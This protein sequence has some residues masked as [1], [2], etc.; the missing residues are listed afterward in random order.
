METTEARIVRTARRIFVEN[1]YERTS[2]GDI[3]AVA[4]VTRTTLH[5]YFRTKD[6]LF[7]AVFGSVVES[8]LPKVQHILGR[9][10]PFEERLE[11][12]IGEY[13]KIFSENPCLP[14]FVLGESR[15]DMD[16][17][18]A[19]VRE[20][21]G[22]DYISSIKRSLLREMERGHI[23][24]VPF[25]VLFLNFYS[26]LTYPF[27]ARDLMGKLFCHDAAEFEAFVAEWKDNVLSQM[28]HLLG[29]R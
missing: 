2:M 1:G 25:P 5:Y 6:R 9:E 22:A 14:A 21:K 26:L 16:H 20:I 17:L 18:F 28:K 4:G 7:Q 11:A 29:I 13:M 15:R 19:F 27:L 8:L 10:I 3:A 12:V 24:T 23:R